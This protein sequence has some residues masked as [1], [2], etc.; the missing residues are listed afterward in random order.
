MIVL[1]S[2]SESRAQILRDFNIPFIQISMDYDE[3]ITQKTSLNSYSM[4]V[5]IQ[6]SKQ[7]FSKFKKQYDNVLFA[8]SSVICKGRILGKAKDEDEAWQMLAL[9]SGSIVSVYT[10]M[11]F[12]STK[13]DIDS[14]SVTT[15]KFDIFQK[16]DL[17]KYVKSGLWKDKAGAMMCEGFN[18]KYI[19]QTNGNKSTA[20]GLNAE[21]L[22]AFL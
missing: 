10:A 12:V 13:F 19:L 5:V 16:D 1:A 15:F 3:T 9:Q 8:D 7:F 20:M 2:S 17:K 6:K 14:L 4:N 22:K 21:I 11:K 18:K